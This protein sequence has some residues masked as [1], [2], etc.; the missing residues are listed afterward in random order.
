MT[1]FKNIAFV[2]LLSAS[3]GPF[4]SSCNNKPKEE[5]TK[6]TAEDLNK[7]NL[8]GS[9]MDMR[10]DA[11]FLV[12]VAEINLK[13]IELG[14]LAQT[15]GI[16]QDVKALGKMMESEHTRNQEELKTLAGQK[17]ITVPTSLTE[18]GKEAYEML[19]KKDGKDFDKAYAEKMV[20][21]HE[22]AIEKFEKEANDASDADIKNWANNTLPALRTHLEH[23]KACKDKTDK[24]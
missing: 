19:S 18:K 24:L 2:L 11:D 22:K 12:E 9:D 23:S 8:K 3:I 14:K 6:E 21:G 5:D 16:T 1:T 7:E 10:R 20:E 13:E 4:V 15:K 17:N